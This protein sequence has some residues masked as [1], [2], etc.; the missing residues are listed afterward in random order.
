MQNRM[1]FPFQKD[2]Q[3][4]SG[5]LYNTVDIAKAKSTLEADGWKLNGNVYEKNG[6]KLEFKLMHKNN[7][8]RSSEE[9]LIAASCG[10]AGISVVD[11]GDDKWSTRLGLGQFDSVVFAWIGSPLLSSQKPL[12]HTPPSKQNLLSNG[13]YYS[14]PQVDTLMDQLNSE[15]DP[16]KLAA[17]A[18]QADKL[19]W[20]DVA[21]IPLFQFVDVVSHTNHVKNVTY[22]P[23]LFSQTWNDNAWA[24]AG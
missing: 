19:I 4:T 5:G 13:G 16:T 18:N 24:V 21:T 11:D 8:R 6:Q 3:D 12:Y 22:N 14:N 1:F 17:A 20:G 7:A 15:T 10:Q 23:T 2:Y 9:Q